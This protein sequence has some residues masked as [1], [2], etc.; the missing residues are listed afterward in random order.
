MGSSNS[1]NKIILSAVMI[2]TGRT[3][4]LANIGP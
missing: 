2:L 4:K 3:P 1:A